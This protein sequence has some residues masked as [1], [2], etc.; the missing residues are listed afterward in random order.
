MYLVGYLV[1]VIATCLD[2]A[3]SFFHFLSSLLTGLLP[4]LLPPT[5]LNAL[6][7]KRYS[8]TYANTETG[9]VETIG[10]IAWELDLLERH[11]I[12]SG[13]MLVLGAGCGRETIAL[14]RRGLTVVGVEAN[15]NAIR[16]ASR[17]ATRA[18]LQS[19][20]HRADFLHLPYKPASFNYLLL[21][22]IMY[23]AIPGRSLRQAWLR[24]LLNVLKPEGLAILSYEARH[25][26]RSRLGA[27]RVRI[28]QI[29]SRLPGA[30]P[31][32]QP[33]DTY[34]PWEHFIHAFQ[35]EEEI[36]A[37]FI[38]AGVS[39][40]EVDWKRGVAVLAAQPVSGT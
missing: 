7:R 4:A 3:G 28:A 22:S 32:Y 34:E 5:Q 14:A 39:I 8:N 38:G 17:L 15:E 2:A 20:F 33:G 24:H 9:F 36:R 18:G 13:C 21:S 19:H 25:H 29:L 10:L 11:N 40:R 31:A 30:N 37:E 6:T 16:T 12:Y 26:P 35:D 1:N 27:L 23:S